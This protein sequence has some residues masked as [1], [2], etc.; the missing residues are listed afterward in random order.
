VSN[1]RPTG[2]ISEIANLVP[3]CG[4]CNQ[5]KGNKPW[6]EW[7]L[8]KA[9]RSPTSRQIANTAERFMRLEAY[10][11]WR[12]PVRVDIEAIVGRDDWEAYWALCEEVNADLRRHQEVADGLRA[13]IAAHLRSPNIATIEQSL[14]T[15]R[16]DSSGIDGCS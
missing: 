4:K 14:P 11:K 5:S 12:T 8:S 13:K 7:M 6:R 9:A 10:E 16:S 15:N 3:A 1:R 2:F